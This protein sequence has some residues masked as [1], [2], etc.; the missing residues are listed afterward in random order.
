MIGMRTHYNFT[1]SLSDLDEHVIIAKKMNR[2]HPRRR[3]YSFVMTPLM[4]GLLIA[5]CL[6]SL[7]TAYLT[8]TVIRELVFSR[9]SGLGI[10]PLS[11]K[12][13]PTDQASLSLSSPLQSDTGPTPQVWDGA[14]R[15]TILAM[16]LDSRD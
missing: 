5:F 15:V 13:N 9:A 16:G 8:F 7:I 2:V 1:P 3:R 12:P 10:K 4:W 14:G 6:A 11:L